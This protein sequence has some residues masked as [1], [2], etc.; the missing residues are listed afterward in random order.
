MIKFFI[1]TLSAAGISILTLLSI[2]SLFYRNSAVMEVISEKEET[3]KSDSP[4]KKIIDDINQNKED[5]P[6]VGLNENSDNLE[7]YVKE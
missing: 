2:D 1:S 5:D 4:K 3:N 6:F 7:M